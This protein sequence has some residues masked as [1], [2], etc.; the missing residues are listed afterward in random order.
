MGTPISLV[1]SFASWRTME[2][3]PSQPTTRSAR[4]SRSPSGV[5]ARTPA[6]RSPSCTRS[7]TL[8]SIRN[9]KAGNC[10]ACFAR[11]LRNSHCGMNP[12]NLHFVGRREK[13]AMPTT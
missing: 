10:F 1:S 2:L 6:I 11:K 4:T 13:S 12:M 7:T 9:S 8:D 5:L 3:R